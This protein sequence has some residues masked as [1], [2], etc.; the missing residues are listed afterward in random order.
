MS[1]GLELRPEQ[2]FMRLS[3]LALQSQ[4]STLVSPESMCMSFADPSNLYEKYSTEIAE[5]REML[6]NDD[7]DSIPYVLG[8]F[9]CH[10]YSKR[11]YLQH[12]DQ[13]SSLD[14]FHIP[15]M[16]REWTTSIKRRDEQ[17]FELYTVTLTSPEEGYFHAINAVLLDKENPQDINSYIF[18]EPQSDKLMLADEI[19]AHS[20]RLMNKTMTAPISI[21]VGTFDEFK[22][23]GNIWQTFSSTKVNF[24]D[25]S[26]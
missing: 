4:I 23:N 25:S 8:H 22:F 15:D 1:Y 21:D 20:N 2:A 26:E 7:T 3:P 24:T 18:I 11:L 16:E 10:N 13:V 5:L 9:S 19:R 6:F 14:P 17:K 12:S